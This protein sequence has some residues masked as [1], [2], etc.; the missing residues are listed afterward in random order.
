M[1]WSMRKWEPVTSDFGKMS[2]SMIFT[3]SN[4]RVAPP[5]LVVTWFSVIFTVFLLEEAELYGEV[6]AG[7]GDGDVN[8]FD[9][10]VTT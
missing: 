4:L 8:P 9:A 5:S 1:D 10:A 7:E 6:L 3:F 2:Q